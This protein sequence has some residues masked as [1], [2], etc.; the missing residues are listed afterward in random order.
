MERER[1]KEWMD[2]W[3]SKATTTG[4]KLALPNERKN[5]L[6]NERKEDWVTEG[7]RRSCRCCK[8]TQLDTR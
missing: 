7:S 8:F 2:G 3:M 6:L 5:E 1:E 4:K